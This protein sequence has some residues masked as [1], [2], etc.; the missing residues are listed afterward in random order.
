MSTILFYEPDHD[1][2]TSRAELED[3]LSDLGVT[4]SAPAGNNYRP[5]VWADAD[6]GSQAIVDCGTAPVEAD[7][8]H[9]A[10]AYAGWLPLALT[11]QIPL[12]VP[13][14]QA[15]EA[16]HF[17]ER[18]CAQLPGVVSFDCEDTRETDDHEPGPFASTRVRA[19][20]SWE[21]QH[22]AQTAGRLDLPRLPRILSLALWRYRKERRAGQT[23]AAD[24]AWPEAHV[25]AEGTSAISVALW[26]DVT[27]D[28]ALPPVSHLVIPRQDGPGLLPIDELLTVAG[29]GLPILTAGKALRITPTA[30]IQDLYNRAKLISHQRFV[31]VS[32]TEWSD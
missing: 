30:A 18:V 21:R 13:H 8:M 15:V 6:T 10:T 27:R 4:F 19:L 17:V 26:A 28:L 22:A 25:L 5:G 24:C 7:E 29:D 3:R 14:W 2:P 9:P 12:S 32:D 16:L 23:A 11:V 1:V 20:A 31:A